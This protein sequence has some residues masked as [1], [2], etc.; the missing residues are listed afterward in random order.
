M[1]PPVESRSGDAKILSYPTPWYLE[2]FHLPE[3]EKLFS[4][5]VSKVFL[6]LLD[7]FL[8]DGYLYLLLID[9][10][11]RKMI[12]LSLSSISMDARRFRLRLRALPEN[13]AAR[14]A[15]LTIS[16]TAALTISI[17]VAVIHL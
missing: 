9:L 17:F 2:C 16:V 1:Q 4:K 6:F 14:M 11:R 8:K 5:G 3:D 13:R 12:S 10:S 15:A 7:P